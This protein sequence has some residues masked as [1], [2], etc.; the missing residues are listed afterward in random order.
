MTYVQEVE[1]KPYK[2]SLCE[3]TAPGQRYCDVFQ[4]EIEL[5]DG[6]KGD[7]NAAKTETTND[8]KKQ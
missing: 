4:E 8:S 6:E 2:V 7:E 1:G 3:S 5:E